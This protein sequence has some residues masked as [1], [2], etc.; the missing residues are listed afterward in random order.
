MNRLVRKGL[1]FLV[2]LSMVFGPGISSLAI[3]TNPGN[4]QV[5]KTAITAEECREF[6]V[7]LEI[8]GEPPEQK[9]DIILVIDRSGSMQGTPLSNAKAAAK[10]FAETV[11]GTNNDSIH[12]VAVVSYSGPTSTWGDGDQNQASLNRTFTNNLSSVK[13]A[14]N[15]LSSGGGTNTEAGLIQAENHLSSARSDAKKVVI[16]L[17]DGVPTSSNGNIYGPND[18]T[19]DNNHT[20]AAKAAGISLKAKA[21]V[22]SIGLFSSLQAG[23]TKNLAIG[24]MQSIQNRGY[25][26]APSSQDLENIYDTISGELSESA[27]NAVVTDIISEEFELV[28]GTF[29]TDPVGSNVQYY[30]NSRT[31]TW[32]PGTIG[33]KATLTYRIKAVADYPGGEDVETNDEAILTY[34]DVD[35]KHDQTKVFPIPKVDVPGKTGSIQIFK[36][37]YG[38]DGS[39][40]IEDDNT[41]FS[42][43]ITG[44]EGFSKTVTATGSE[45]SE[46]VE[47]L[48]AGEYT[49]TETNVNG[50]EIIGSVETSFDLVID[51]CSDDNHHEITFKNK[52]IEIIG[53]TVEKIWVGGESPRPDVTINLLA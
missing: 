31:I 45:P 36:E 48:V 20:L 13:S 23:A 28:P 33:T 17:S 5:D 27:T 44:P 3:T 1:A 53:I 26:D 11:L 29:I 4:I 41:P 38:G 10:A 51:H 50:Y 8:T 47:G 34:T 14:I 7:T 25:Y 6:E 19:S 42:F 2:A 46:V 9:L 37:V 15:G 12:R 21:D 30:A 18:P 43:T 22:F 16:F 52:T 24:V 39:T 32:E 49:I 35:G 40:L